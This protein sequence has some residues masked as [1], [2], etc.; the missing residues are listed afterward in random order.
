MG[1][2][3]LIMG[4]A[5]S[6]KS[7][8]AERMAKDK[9]GR[10][11]FV[12]TAQPYDDEMRHRIDAH[13]AARPAGWTTIEE[14]LDIARS[15]GEAAR[16]SDV[17][18]VDCLTLWVSNYI[19]GLSE[20]NAQPEDSEWPHHVDR[21]GAELGQQITD[22][23]AAVRSHGAILLV[24]SNEVGLGLVPPNALSRAFR[25]LL[26]AV[27]RQMAMEANQVLLMVAGIP[28]DVKRLAMDQGL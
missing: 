3:V 2:I 22:L 23:A 14:P 19:C 27:N 10:V 17:I 15:V 12:A 25:E 18:I 26:G 21:L 11:T 28:V 20:A 16:G 7:S 1:R 5:R 8:L 4:G 13:R 24:V 6:G 9:G